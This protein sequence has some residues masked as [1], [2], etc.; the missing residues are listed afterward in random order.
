ML[1]VRN[2][3]EIIGKTVMHNLDRT[4]QMRYADISRPPGMRVIRGFVLLERD[5]QLK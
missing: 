5:S 3:E 2:Q 4:W 1:R